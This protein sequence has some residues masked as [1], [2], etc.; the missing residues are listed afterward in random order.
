MADPVVSG[1]GGVQALVA[2]FTSGF[3]FACL[4]CLFFVF[5]ESR[6]FFNILNWTH[7]LQ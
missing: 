2:K 4:F 6:D 7:I 3:L 5:L 1:V